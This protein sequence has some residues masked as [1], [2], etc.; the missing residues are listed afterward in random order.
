MSHAVRPA[1]Q[2]SSRSWFQTVVGGTNL[3]SSIR[4]IGLVLDF[5]LI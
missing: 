5:F 1:L 2:V 4:L 3:S